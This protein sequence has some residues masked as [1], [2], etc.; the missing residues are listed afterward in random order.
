MIIFLMR[1]K[2]EILSSKNGFDVIST[3][4]KFASL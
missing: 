4:K 3:K 1:A 2:K